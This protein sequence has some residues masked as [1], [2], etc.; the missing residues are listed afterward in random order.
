VNGID[1]NGESLMSAGLGMVS[2]IAANI[3]RSIAVF[4]VQ[5]LALYTVSSILLNG[6]IGAISARWI[7]AS[8]PNVSPESLNAAT[9]WGGLSGMAFGAVFPIGIV[10]A[11]TL[12][13][14]GGLGLLGLGSYEA[15]KS[16]WQG[17]PTRGN[18]IIVSMIVSIIANGGLGKGFGV[19]EKPTASAISPLRPTWVDYWC[20][21][22]VETITS[23]GKNNKFFV[24]KIGTLHPADLPPISASG[25]TLGILSCR[26]GDIPLVSGRSG[27][28]ETL[29]SG[30]QGMNMVTKTHVEG[31]AAALMRTYQIM[32]ADLY[33]NNPPCSNGPTSCDALLPSMLPTGAKLIIHSPDGV[34]VYIGK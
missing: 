24:K 30:T 5:R 33:I 16:Y 6:A 34:K 10:L 15:I 32:Q 3:G 29:P 18:R 23:Y 9:F 21:R 12:T 4:G 8:D 28:A 2:S 31:H 26:D 1:P 19:F 17:N 27:P 25:K 20:T 7:A 22:F 13:T 11:P 14:I